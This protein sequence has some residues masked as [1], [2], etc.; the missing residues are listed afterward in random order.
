M[1]GSLFSGHGA[2][3]RLYVR[4]CKVRFS[5][6]DRRYSKCILSEDDDD[7]DDDNNDNADND[8][9]TIDK[10]NF[11]FESYNIQRTKS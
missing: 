7:D 10:V 4:H 6:V 9:A 2:V 5:K 8:D 11:C 1:W 3:A